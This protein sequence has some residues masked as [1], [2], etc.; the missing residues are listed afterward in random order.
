VR[1]RGCVPRPRAASEE[2][3]L[4]DLYEEIANDPAIRLDMELRPGDVQLVSNH[5]VI[6][7]HTAYGDAAS[8]SGRPHRLRLWLSL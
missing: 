3:A 8:S 7:A 5:S 2:Q 1:L 4:L 6:H